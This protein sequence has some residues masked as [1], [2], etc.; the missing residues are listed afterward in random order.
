MMSSVPAA[1]LVVVLKHQK[2][3]NPEETEIFRC[4]AASLKCFMTVGIL[5]RQFQTY[6]TRGD[7]L[8]FSA[9]GRI[10]FR[11]TIATA[12]RN[13]RHNQVVRPGAAQLANFG[14]SF[15]ALFLQLGK[16]VKNAHEILDA[17]GN[18]FA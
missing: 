4:I 8:R 14:C 7:E 1:L 16:A 5:T 6:L 18:F 10:S 2:I 11:N 12:N 9:R 3:R 17:P 15:R 13:Y